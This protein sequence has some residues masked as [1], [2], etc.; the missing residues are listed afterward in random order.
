MRILSL[1]D[2]YQTIHE[3]ASVHLKSSLWNLT[4]ARHAKAAGHCQEDLVASQVRQ[5]VRPRVILLPCNSNSSSSSSSKQ[6]NEPSLQPEEN[7]MQQKTDDDDDDND[8]NNT[9]SRP[10]PFDLVDPVEEERKRQA[11]AAAAGGGNEDSNQTLSNEEASGLRQRKKS[12]SKAATGAT[13]TTTTTASESPTA[14]W[15]IIQEEDYGGGGGDDE[16]TRLR[17]VDPLELFGG[18]LNP[19]TLRVAQQEARQALEVYVRAAN[20]KR[21]IEFELK[22]QSSN[23]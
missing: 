21:A 1:L 10:I 8:K 3:E 11:A 22:Q 7:E 5:D 15:T 9:I 13:T 12:S 17:K 16:E 18:G 2:S 19:R 23:K 4:K 20:L 14:A 6:N